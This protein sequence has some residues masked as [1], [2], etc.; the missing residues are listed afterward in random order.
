MIPQDLMGLGVHPSGGA[1]G[2]CSCW[3]FAA[4]TYQEEHTHCPHSQ[5]SEET[6]G[7]GV[8]CHSEPHPTLTDSPRVGSG[9]GL[10]SPWGLLLF[11]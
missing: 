1:A 5:E 9:T 7:R 8:Q 2:D 11:V 10:S 6:M 4:I 3:E